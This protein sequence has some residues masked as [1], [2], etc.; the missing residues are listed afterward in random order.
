MVRR[1]TL[2][3]PAPRARQ[4]RCDISL[5]EWIYA[6]ALGAFLFA[7]PL[8]FRDPRATW[9]VAVLTGAILVDFLVTVLP[10]MGVESLS[11]NATGSNLSL[12]LGSVTGLL[13]WLLFAAAM[14]ARRRERMRQYLGLVLATQITWFVCYLSFLFG[15]HVVPM[16]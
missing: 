1:L 3:W 13:T 15:L 11:F 7:V 9:P 12:V 8:T 4:G 5:A 2:Q 16:R 14:L 6:C 10:L